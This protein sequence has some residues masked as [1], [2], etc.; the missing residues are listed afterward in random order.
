MLQLREWVGELLALA[1]SA[2]MLGIMVGLLAYY[3]GRQIFDLDN[4]G[5]TLN[6]I[7]SLL[8]TLCKG[9]LATAIDKSVGQWKW[10]LFSREPARGLVEFDQID[11]ASRGAQGSLSLLCR[12]R[13]PSVSSSLPCG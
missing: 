3:D 1:G 9:L 7:V 12:Y 4:Y 6:A 11:E 8:A 5:I 10:L 13:G 2:A